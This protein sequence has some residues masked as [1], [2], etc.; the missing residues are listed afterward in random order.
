M[1]YSPTTW[2]TGDT[3]TAS[4]LNNIEQGLAAAC[5]LICNLAWSSTYSEYALDKTVG[6]IYNA[7]LAGIPVFVKHQYGALLPTT[8]YVGHLW[9]APVV[10]VYNYDYTNVIRVVAVKSNSYATIG[11]KT[12]TYGPST[13]IFSASGIDSYPLFYTSVQGTKTTQE[14]TQSLF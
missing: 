6:E 9:L 10:K 3:I 11:Q 2:Q 1:S 8:D 12:E 7:L 4:G 13:I 14:T 5:P